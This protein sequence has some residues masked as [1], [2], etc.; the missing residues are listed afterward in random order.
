[1]KLLVK[2]VTRSGEHHSIQWVKCGPVRRPAPSLRVRVFRVSVSL[3]RALAGP[4]LPARPRQTDSVLKVKQ[5]LAY[6]TI[7]ADPAHKLLFSGRVLADTDAVNLYN[8]KQGNFLVAMADT[9]ASS[10]DEEPSEEEPHFV[11]EGLM[12]FLSMQEELM[13]FLSIEGGFDVFTVPWG[14]G[15]NCAT[16]ATGA[17]SEMQMNAGSLC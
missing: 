6:N 7:L 11:P 1:M 16:G 13:D 9:G 8:I 2:T 17:D 12:D 4:Q 3:P 14:F 15:R 10:M 5:K